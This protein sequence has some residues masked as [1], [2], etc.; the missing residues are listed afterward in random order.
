MF[1]KTEKD[2]A[3]IEGTDKLI[4]FWGLVKMPSGKDDLHANFEYEIVFFV[5]SNGIK[6]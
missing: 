2:G 4:R 3:L 5:Y 6:S 1:G